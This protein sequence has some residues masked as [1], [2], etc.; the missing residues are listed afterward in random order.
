VAREDDRFEVRGPFGGWFVW[1]PRVT[2][3][4]LLIA[5]GSGL[6]P[7]MS[8]LRHRR[9]TGSAVPAR[10]LVSAREADDLLYADELSHTG[11]EVFVTYT[12]RPPRGWTGYARRVDRGLLRELELPG[13]R[14]YVCGP[15]GFVES[16]ANDLV[17]LGVDPATIRTERFGATGG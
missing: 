8:I 13:A 9:A 11:A 5:G 15:T 16:V 14:T 1:D 7:L 10:L 6:V 4:L 2:E 3:P 12:R 17:A